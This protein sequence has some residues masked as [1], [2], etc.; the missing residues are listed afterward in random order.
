MNFTQVARLIQRFV[1]R[2]DCPS[3][4]RTVPFAAR[5]RGYERGLWS[6]VH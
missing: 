5:A 6:P 3:D 4:Y 2:A 1:P